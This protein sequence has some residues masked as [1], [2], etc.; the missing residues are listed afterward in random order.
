VSEVYQP[1]AKRRTVSRKTKPV[2]GLPIN[3]RDDI[4]EPAAQFIIPPVM[5]PRRSPSTTAIHTLPRGPSNEQRVPVFARQRVPLSPSTFEEPITTVSSC[6]HIPASGS[7]APRRRLSSFSI[8]PPSLP[9]EPAEAHAP[10][11]LTKTEQASVLR[12]QKPVRKRSILLDDKTSSRARPPLIRRRSPLAP[13]N[14]HPAVVLPQK[15]VVG[16]PCTYPPARPPRSRKRST[17]KSTRA[18]GEDRLSV[19]V[20]QMKESTSTS[21]L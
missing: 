18:R 6:S 12:A 11:N 10:P 2:S 1:P 5:R 13:P 14:S 4:P 20:F 9:I 7:P 21:N 19:L 8:T 3:L 17:T 15:H 16:R